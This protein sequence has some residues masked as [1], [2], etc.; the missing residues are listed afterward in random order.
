VLIGG[1]FLV[2]AYLSYNDAREVTI[3][4]SLARLDAYNQEVVGQQE[5][6]FRRLT[7]TH[8]N[9]T[10]LLRAEM[11]TGD[12][13]E[14][15]R[16]F[17]TMMPENGDGTRRTVPALFDGT[18]TPFGYVRGIGGF[19]G[20]EPDQQRK[21][22]LMAA[23]RVVHAIGEGVRP[24]LKNLSFFTPDNTLI[25]FAPDRPDKLLFYR[26]DAGPELDFRASEFVTITR[27]EHNPARTTRCTTL[28]PILYDKT[29]QTWT[30]GCHTPIDIDGVHV[31]AWGNSL[32]LD[33]ILATSHFEDHPGTSV[34]LVSGEGRLISHPVFTKQGTAATERY[35]DLKTSSEPKLQALWK[36]LQ[37]HN[38]D[39]VTGFSPELNGYVAI[40]RIPIA[41]W[42]AVTIQSASYVEAP[43]RRSL[44][45]LILIALVCLVLQAVLLFVFLRQNVGRPLRALIRQAK[46]LTARVAQRASDHVEQV[47][48]D[49]VGALTAYFHTMSQEILRAHTMLENRVTERT[50]QLQRANGELERLAGCDPLTGLYNRRKIL[51]L[52]E[53]AV[54]EAEAKGQFSLLIFDVDHFKKVNDTHGHVIGDRVLRAVA[55]HT[56]ATL[57][58]EDAMARIG[59]EEFLILLPDTTASGAYEV[60]ERVRETLAALEMAVG[61]CQ[62]VRFTVS[63]G[64]TEH[65]PGDCAEAMYQRA[66]DALYIA[67]RSGRNQTRSSAA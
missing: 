16:A 23:I 53:Q 36:V 24:D 47:R 18:A 35:L 40:R 57:R 26:R 41:G 66:D 62:A 29:N 52:L 34:I 45:R 39:H 33:D 55:E 22:L 31:G 49:E 11:R 3:S 38:D 42:F 30:T 58:P 20:V 17:E 56:L 67:K 8:Q 6:R 12:D 10:M 59:G 5:D 14:R 27:P 64:L 63:L 46:Q 44:G 19:V 32:L 54:A 65:V 7:A 50:L 61:D 28:Q 13:T 2:A 60:A 21:S 51:Q 37:Q 1:L 43:A 25:M 48:E 15:R 9:A 4:R